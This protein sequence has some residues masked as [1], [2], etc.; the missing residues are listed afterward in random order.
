MIGAFSPTVV[1]FRGVL[2]RGSYN[3]YYPFAVAAVVKGNGPT[4][5]VF[6]NIGFPRRF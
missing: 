1:V 6:I 3:S 4:R 2:F 5:W